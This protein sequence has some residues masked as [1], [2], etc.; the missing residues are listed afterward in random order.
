M[1]QT[2]ARTSSLELARALR[3]RVLPPLGS[4]AGRAHGVRRRRGRRDV[5]HRRRRRGATSRT[6]SPRARPRVAFYSEDRGLVDAGPAAPSTCWSSTR[7]TA[8][9]RPWP[10]SRRPACRSR[11]RRWRDG[12]PTM[13][14][15]RGRL[16]GGDQVRRALPRRARRGPGAPTCRWRL[17]ANADLD[18]LF[19]TYGL[20]GRPGARD[21]RGP[22]RAD[23]PLLGGRRRRSTSGSATYDMT[24]V[25]TG[26]LDAYV[27]PGPADDRRGAG[28]ARR[29]SSASAAAPCSTTRPTTSPPPPCALTRGRR[30]RH[31]RRRAAA[32]RPA[33]ARRRAP[34]SRCRCSWRPTR[35][36]HERLLAEVDRGHR[37]PPRAARSRGARA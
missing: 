14:D 23:R 17:S 10:A 34:T 19:W 8:P 25:L 26:Q 36:L 5:R 31:R 37:A 7:S 32:R 4:H 6:S 15:V 29:S 9:A 1:S 13:G 3:E 35:T 12:E 18:R 20:R 2:A 24:R 27:E 22:R 30:G 16:R 33:A 21:D 28:H 11:A